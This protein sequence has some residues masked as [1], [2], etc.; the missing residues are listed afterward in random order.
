MKDK[1]I[2]VAFATPKLEIYF[3]KL[4][5]GKSE[6]K[7]LYDFIER[8]IKDLKNR[9]TCGTKIPKNFWPKA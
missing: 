7:Q 5:K 8:A 1:P 3:E 2:H 9:P 6:D 4:R